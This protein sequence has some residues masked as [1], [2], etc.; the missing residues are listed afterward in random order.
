MQGC[1]FKFCGPEADLDHDTYFAR[2]QVFVNQAQT[3]IDS[4]INR[5]PD[6]KEQNRAATKEI[7]C[8]FDFLADFRLITGSFSEFCRTL[9]KM[10]A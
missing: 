10:L 3:L 1:V 5:K 4:V 6:Q 8:Q 7:G 9:H 2:A